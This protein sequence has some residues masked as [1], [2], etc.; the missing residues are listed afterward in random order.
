MQHSLYKKGDITK[1]A[2]WKLALVKKMEQLDCK[3]DFRNKRDFVW[4][5]NACMNV[6]DRTFQKTPTVI[7]GY[8]ANLMDNYRSP[9]ILMHEIGHVI[10]YKQYSHSL[11]RYWREMGTLEMEIRAWEHA[12]RLARQVG[13]H[14]FQEMH[15]FAKECLHGYWH[16][17]YWRK[18]DRGFGFQGTP[19]TWEEAQE[20]LLT[21]QK[22]AEKAVALVLSR[23]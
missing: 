9:I 16:G 3:Y 4:D 8:I 21:A 10:D 23:T 1:I 20:R 6:Q 19:P 5:E 14:D 2:Q 17:T 7:L 12:F 15:D 11:E 13:F 18:A 22:Q